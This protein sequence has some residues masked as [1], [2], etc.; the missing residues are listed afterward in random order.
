MEQ[1]FRLLYEQIDGKSVLEHILDLPGINVAVLATGERGYE[2][3]L[4]EVGRQT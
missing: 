4:E 2:D 3:F 1:K